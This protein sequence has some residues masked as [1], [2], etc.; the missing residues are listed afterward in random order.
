MTP[1][2]RRVIYVLLLAVAATSFVMAAL[3]TAEPEPPDRPADI[4]AVSPVENA[5][6]V[7]QTTVFAELAG[8][9]DGAL[10]I[11]NTEIP[12]DQVDRLQTGNLRLSFSPG[13]GKEFES[14]PA[15]KSCARVEY[16]PRGQQRET[17]SKAY[18]WCFTLQ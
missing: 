17:T 3:L 12:D 11:R 10:I 13:E 8:D 14:F 7:R 9:V 2:R 15:G 4:V 16:W 18:A 5:N 1:T 6:D